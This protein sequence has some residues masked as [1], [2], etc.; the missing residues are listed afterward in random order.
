MSM[1]AVLREP[2]REGTLAGD[3]GEKGPWRPGTLAGDPGG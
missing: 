3:T 1:G 2:W